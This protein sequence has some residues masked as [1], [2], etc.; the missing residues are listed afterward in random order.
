MVFFDENERVTFSVAVEIEFVDHCLELLFV[1]RIAQITERNASIVAEKQSSLLL[2]PSDTSQL[3]Q[4]DFARF[5]IV[6]QFEGFQD[7]VA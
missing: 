4:R 5:I 3:F 2:L 6:E 1:D 7:L